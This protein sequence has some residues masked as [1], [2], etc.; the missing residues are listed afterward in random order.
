MS[1]TSPALATA[2][3]RDR[4]RRCHATLAVTAALFAAALG[5][6]AAAPPA[7]LETVEG[8]L[9]VEV[10]ASGL[11]FPWS[12]VALP[13]GDWL[14]SEK[15]PGRLRRL[16]RAGRLAPPLDGVPEVYAEG[17]GGLLGLALD[18]AFADNGYVY[19]AYS[20]LATDG[21]SGLNVGR[22]RLEATRLA[23]VEI[24]FRQRPKW[25]DFRN[26]GGRLVFAPDGTL[27]VFTG[28]RFAQDLV[29]E[30]DNT[31][32]VVARIRPD[33]GI[34]PDNPFV[35]V[36]GAD[37]AIWSFGHRNIGGAGFHPA[38]GRLWL[39]EF[40]PWGGDELNLPEPGH[41]YGWPLV[42]W[43]HHYTGEPIPPPTTRPDLERAI[44]FWE[45]VISPSG[46][47]FYD[48][49]AL[50][51]WRGNLLIGGLSSQSLVRLVLDGERVV[52]E[53][54]LAMGARIRDVQVDRDG[55]VLLLTDDAEGQLLRL[56]PPATP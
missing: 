27:F 35:G 55:S 47:V 16:D 30:L 44:F 56:R 45:P 48:G 42:S 49:D 43:G 4:W 40:G 1:R 5:T 54:R 11:S 22:G 21:T 46:F 14:V 8:P 9:E 7:A 13:E 6:A 53:E 38:T 34:P 25:D 33:G 39:H 15:I 19:F 2:A 50:P 28:D 36:E 12:L 52:S 51:A 3:A 23:D 17:N 41:N 24:I 26:F 37:P 29:Q 31:I 18:P 10:V 32:G 20:E